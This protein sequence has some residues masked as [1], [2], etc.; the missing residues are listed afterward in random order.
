MPIHRG[1]GWN[2]LKHGTG[3]ARKNLRK[4]HIG[5]DLESG[6]IIA[7]TL[8][9]DHVGV[10]T[11][12]PILIAGVNAP[13]AKVL[14]DGAYD[15]V[16]VFGS[17]TTQFGAEVEVIIP[18]PKSATLGKYDQRDANIA[19]IAKLGR[20]AW[21]ADT[22]ATIFAPVLKPRSGVGKWSWVTA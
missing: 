17:L 4:L 3:K 13:V 2:E 19:H 11:A 15:G 9:T 14:A 20:M 8:T 1:S 22:G 10:E 7:S 16:G 5:L 21:Q 12:L 6:E 18:P